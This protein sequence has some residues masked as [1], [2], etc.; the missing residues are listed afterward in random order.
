MAAHAPH[1]VPEAGERL[2]VE[3]TEEVHHRAAL[4][5]ERGRRYSIVLFFV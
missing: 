5:L 2:R 1:P 4:L 3:R